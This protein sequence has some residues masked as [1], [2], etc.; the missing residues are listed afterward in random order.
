MLQ[1]CPEWPS[2]QPDGEPYATIAGLRITAEQG[3]EGVIWVVEDLVHHRVFESSFLIVAVLVYFTQPHR[4]SEAATDL[5]S[6]VPASVPRIHSM[7]SRLVELELLVERVVLDTDARLAS[8]HILE[9]T[10]SQFGWSEAA[11]HFL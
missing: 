7:I 3:G 4:P 2:T 11:D 6:I 1:G 5:A 8:A 9:K 10:W